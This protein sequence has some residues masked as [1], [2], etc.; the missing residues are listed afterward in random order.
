MMSSPTNKRSV[1]S[2]LENMNSLIANLEIKENT[3]SQT[4]VR[5]LQDSI[6]QL[7]WKVTDSKIGC[8]EELEELL[9]TFKSGMLTPYQLES[10]FLAEQQKSEFIL[11]LSSRIGQHLAALCDQFQEMAAACAS[12]GNNSVISEHYEDI[13]A[14]LR[15]MCSEVSSM[16]KIINSPTS[17]LHSTIGSVEMSLAGFDETMKK[18]NKRKFSV[19]ARLTADDISVTSDGSARSPLH[20][21]LS[22]ASISKASMDA[23]A[24][25][26]NSATRGSPHTPVRQQQQFGRLSTTRDEPVKIMVDADAQTDTVENIPDAPGSVEAGSPKPLDRKGAAKHSKGHSGHNKKKSGHGA[27]DSDKRSNKTSP[28]SSAEVLRFK[29]VHELESDNSLV[30]ASG[31]VLRMDSRS[32]DE[33]EEPAKRKEAETLLE[34]TNVKKEV[35]AQKAKIAE[36]EGL[37]RK[38]QQTYRQDSF[39]SDMKISKASMA[40]V[41]QMLSDALS[42]ADAKKIDNNNHHPLRDPSFGFTDSVSTVGNESQVG[43][44]QLNQK[45]NHLGNARGPTAAG[46]DGDATF[47]SEEES[48]EVDK[49]VRSAVRSS[50]LPFVHDSATSILECKVD[51]G[52]FKSL[53]PLHSNNPHY[54][55]NSTI[56][57]MKHASMQP[58]RISTKDNGSIV[59]SVI[60]D[61]ARNHANGQQVPGYDYELDA[62]FP[63]DNND[64]YLIGEYVGH[65]P[66]GQRPISGLPGSRPISGNK[67]TLSGKY[68]RQTHSRI[69]SA[70]T[71]RITSGRS[72]RGQSAHGRKAVTTAPSAE[73]I[74]MAHLD[75]KRF[76][77]LTPKGMLASTMTADSSMY[78]NNAVSAIMRNKDAK[79]QTALTVMKAMA[80]NDVQSN[81]MQAL[82]HSLEN[83][84]RNSRSCGT[85]DLI[86]YCHE[87][88]KSLTQYER[89]LVASTAAVHSWSTSLHYGQNAMLSSAYDDELLEMSVSRE[90]SRDDTGRRLDPSSGAGSLYRQEITVGGVDILGEQCKDSVPIDDEGN[91][92]DSSGYNDRGTR[93][94]Q[95]YQP[96]QGSNYYEPLVQNT[97]PAPSMLLSASNSF[98]TAVTPNPGDSHGL[99]LPVSQQGRRATSALTRSAEHQIENR[100]P[101]RRP[102]SST[103]AVGKDTGMKLSSKIMTVPTTETEKEFRPAES[104]TRSHVGSSSDN[105]TSR[106]VGSPS[107]KLALSPTIIRLGHTPVEL[108]L[109]HRLKSAVNPLHVLY[110]EYK[111]H[112]NEIAKSA[113]VRAMYHELFLPDPSASRTQALNDNVTREQDEQQQ[114]LLP[115]QARSPSPSGRIRSPSP[116]SPTDTVALTA[117]QMHDLQSLS[118]TLCLP[119][120]PVAAMIPANT[121][122]VADHP[123]L[124]G[125]SSP[126]TDVIEQAAEGSDGT[127]GPRHGNLVVVDLIDSRLDANAKMFFE[128]CHC[129]LAGL[130]T[131]AKFCYSLLDTCEQSVPVLITLSGVQGQHGLDINSVDP[132][133]YNRSVEAVYK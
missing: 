14:K 126:A 75:T 28:G 60:F 86:P 91:A 132:L 67:M 98:V 19:D 10:F 100:A 109:A 120:L 81:Y 4:E 59:S 95:P 124:A 77:P 71:S 15:I 79:W 44:G 42:T 128:E 33:N 56:D 83:A 18:L 11:N 57:T 78:N 74:I 12:D 26:L 133:V 90:G 110:F 112:L 22:A 97:I 32:E 104:N 37:L 17:D 66:R 130:N 3:V 61:E 48:V 82:Q 40:D 114:H 129:L 58:P 85:E 105:G 21:K 50:S 127:K 115:R 23:A 80:T 87:G 25:R 125:A 43:G 103:T 131:K 108:D 76:D 101:Q 117:L 106:R 31:A 113:L 72:V 92:H 34:L 69:N 68:G 118:S 41:S 96:H 29:A 9:Y 13:G 45:I 107:S 49:K 70:N 93:T 5:E 39:E 55:A 6:S 121:I 62:E 36:L 73:A 24:N 65:F 119:S 102:K 123:G 84:A 47:I 51:G 54:I 38:A 7:M 20:S 16:T 52:G 8:Y 99:L 27:V 116:S 2:A 89:I 1:E 122:V 88:T 64:D 46:D 30:D 35:K 63:V 94:N 111:D 53:Q